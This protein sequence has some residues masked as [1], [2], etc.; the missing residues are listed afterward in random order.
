MDLR[1]LGLLFLRLSLGGMLLVGH[2]WSKLLGFAD[3]MDHFPDPLGVGPRVSLGLVVLAEVLCTAAVMVGFKTRKAVV[4]VIGFA[5]VAAF[6]FHG[7]DPFGKREL[8][9]VYGAWAT[10]LLLTGPGR[11]SLDEQL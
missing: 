6:V 3:K 11:Y 7:D 1:S 2:G 5:L 8:A 9:L 4:P 10:T